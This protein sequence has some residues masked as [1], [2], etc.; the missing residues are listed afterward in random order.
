MGMNYFLLLDT[1][2][3]GL[4]L[5]L[6]QYEKDGASTLKTLLDSFIHPVRNEAFTGLGHEINALIGRNHLQHGDI[7]GLVIGI[8]PGSF[9]GIRI[10]MAFVQGLMAGRHGKG[11]KNLLVK[12][13]S[14]LEALGLWFLHNPGG[15][16]KQ[17][18]IF[19]STATHAYVAVVEKRDGQDDRGHFSGRLVGI[20][21][22][23]ESQGSLMGTDISDTG[24]TLIE[25]NIPSFS[26]A[27]EKS[28]KAFTLK[29]AQDVL[30]EII[31]A[32]KASI[33]A[34]FPLGFKTELPVAD[35]ARLSTAEERIVK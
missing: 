15:L 34:D 19:P 8:G 3:S 24:I 4:A 12:G 30:P 18:V 31:L 14:T 16:D 5:G 29:S 28:G 26:T 7:D 2:L 21:E 1:S 25:N 23:A 13:V 32:L 17:M 33:G 10:G 35:Y 22:L 9:T 11:E 6:V 27:L 20:K